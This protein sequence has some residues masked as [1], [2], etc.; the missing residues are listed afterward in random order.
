MGCGRV[1]PKGEL[2]RIVAERDAGAGGARAVT[3]ERGTLPGRGAYLCLDG[4]AAERGAPA[5]ACLTL[6]VRR[7]AIPR[8]LRAAVTLDPKLVES[9]S[10]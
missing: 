5:L 4:A 7:R 9:V 3:D 8:A 10:R 1:A 6:A 2:V